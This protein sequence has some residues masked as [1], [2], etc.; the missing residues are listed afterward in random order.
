[1]IQQ[2]LPDVPDTTTAG[3]IPAAAPATTAA[4]T[5]EDITSTADVGIGTVS[6][7]NAV[8]TAAAALIE[9]CKAWAVDRSSSARAEQRRSSLFSD[10]QKSPEV[11]QKI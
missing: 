5:S 7:V 6:F 2:Q 10:T 3:R 11:E 1:M 9:R 8:A 4:A